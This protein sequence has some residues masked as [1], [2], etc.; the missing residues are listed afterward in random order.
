MAEESKSKSLEQTAQADGGSGKRL[1]RVLLGWVLVPA[2]VI[3]ALFAAG[4]HVGAR[5]PDMLLTRGVL[6]IGGGEVERPP[7]VASEPALAEPAALPSAESQP[8]ELIELSFGWPAPAQAIVEQTLGTFD[9]TAKLRYR[10]ELERQGEELLVHHRDPRVLELDGQP[11]DSNSKEAEI[12]GQLLL[13]G[14]MPSMAVS[15]DGK[16]LRVLDMDG[17]VQRMR[18][19]LAASSEQHEALAALMSSPQ[20]ESTLTQRVSNIWELWA[21]MWSELEIKSDKGIRFE[22]HEKVGEYRVVGFDAH[23]VSLEF[24][25]DE[26]L[27]NS[28][29]REMFEPLARQQGLD[30]SELDAKLEGA[31]GG[32]EVLITVILRRDTMLP[33]SSSYQQDT[34]VEFPGQ[35]RE[36]QREQS[37]YTFEWQ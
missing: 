10:I 22:S 34:W 25:V 11:V 23:A 20:L 32:E 21:E 9:D 26:E 35:A 14:F 3:G 31:K 18:G 2:L 36:T 5:H 24:R 19:A 37:R 17:Y 16:F 8:P 27:S 15:P 1:R 4:A 28:E 30:A 13:A 7:Q 6:W 33:L 29:L 12:E